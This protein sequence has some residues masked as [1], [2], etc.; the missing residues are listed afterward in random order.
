MTNNFKKFYIILIVFF[1]LSQVNLALAV[2]DIINVNQGVVG[3]SV[4]NVNGICELY[5]NEDSLNCPTDCPS[6]GVIIPTP[7]PPL[8][9][10]P[11]P[12]AEIVPPVEVV[13]PVEKP[14]E[15][16]KPTIIEKV[17]EVLKPLIPKFLEQ[18]P[19]EIVSIEVPAEKVV[20]VEDITVFDDEW[21][22]LPSEPISKIDLVQVSKEIESIVE[23]FPGLEAVFKEIGF[24]QISDIEKLQNIELVLPGLAERA[25]TDVVIPIAEMSLEAKQQLPSEVVFARAG[26]ESIDFNSI[27]TINKEGQ[28][29]QKISTISGKS[30]QLAVKVGE[31]T[32]SVKGYVNFKSMAFLPK[33][34]KFSFNSFFSSLIF[35]NPAFAAAQKEQSGAEEKREFEYTDPDKDGIYTAEIK[36]PTVV[37]EY[38]ITTVMNY[39]DSKLGNRVI[40]LITVIDPEGY[41]YERKGKRETRI[42]GATVAIY[43]LN[44]KTDKYE[45]WPAKQ[46]NQKNSQITDIR[47]TYAFLVPKGFYYLK[48]E[49]PEYLAYQGEPFQVKAGSGVHINVELK[50]KYQWF[51]IANW[52]AVLLIIIIVL[53]F[54]WLYRKG[55]KEKLLDEEKSNN[56]EINN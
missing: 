28:L 49:A 24:S 38:E 21:E 5:R 10:P 42:P 18:K 3:E 7:P 14:V 32:E 46:Y 56:E 20:L 43:W 39:K 44:S 37:G 25:G 45:L 23:K 2:S 54:Y 55:K 52:T 41:I 30:L 12:P 11:T 8:P 51:K 6:S 48:V 16:P 27:L 19:A 47:G 4:C 36:A 26:G 9:P 1:L 13:P 53:V 29:Q 33:A 50:A 31:P 34:E 22:L 35:V 15:Q 40:K 17:L